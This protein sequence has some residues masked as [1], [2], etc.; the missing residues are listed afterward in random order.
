MVVKMTCALKNIF[1]C[2]AVLRKSVYHKMLSEAIVGLNKIM[3]TS[4]VVIDGLVVNG[5]YTKQLNLVMASEN[6]VA[7]DVAAS[8]LLGLNPKFG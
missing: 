2:N 4:L 5:K 1:G 3:R 8:W 6:V 7:A